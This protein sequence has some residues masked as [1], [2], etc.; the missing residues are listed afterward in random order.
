MPLLKNVISPN[1][2]CLKNL[3]SVESI[4]HR[5]KT[6]KLQSYH[7]SPFSSLCLDLP[8][9]IWLM[10]FS[11][12]SPFDVLRWRSVSKRFKKLIDEILQKVL[13]LDVCKLDLSEMLLSDGKTLD[14]LHRHPTASILLSQDVH[15]ITLIVHE[16]WISRD[17]TRLFKAIRTFGRWAHTITMDAS[18]AEML[19]AGLSSIDLS[20]WLSFQY[21]ISSLSNDENRESVHIHGVHGNKQVLVFPNLK[22]FTL[23]VS[24][25]EY[26]CLRR[27][28]DYGVAAEEIFSFSTIELFRVNFQR[29]HMYLKHT[30]Q[31]HRWHI[32][33]R[34]FKQWIRSEA[35]SDRYIQTYANI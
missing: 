23:R 13:Y 7:R 11:K 1:I 2:G 21:Y 6:K 5:G 15:S 28:S 33:L 19:I 29:S 35:L 24:D 32:Y 20:T 27:M 22:E 12:S 10:V 3:L 16:K 14:S 31:H 8:D 34:D 30:D 26:A 9:T 18:V 4:R 25:N 17:V